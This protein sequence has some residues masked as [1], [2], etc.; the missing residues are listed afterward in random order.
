LNALPFFQNIK[1]ALTAGGTGG[2]TWHLHASLSRKKWQFTRDEIHKELMRG[3]KITAPQKIQL[4]KPEQN[5]VETIKSKELV[6]IGAS[7][8]WMMSTPWLEEFSLINAYDIDPLS[9][10]LFNINHGKALKRKGIKVK[11]HT[12]D[13]IHHLDH[14]LSS[15]PNAYIWFDNVLGQH[16]IRLRNADLANAQL[17]II[18]LRLRGRVWGSVH[19]LYSGPSTLKEHLGAQEYPKSVSVVR[20]D[21]NT[22]NQARVLYNSKEM[23]LEKARQTF[24]K[25]LGAS[26]AN[27]AWLDHETSN[28]FPVKTQLTWTGWAFKPGYYH[29]LEMGWVTPTLK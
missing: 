15:H 5:Q 18:Q 9:S 16:R 12:L 10:V 27:G 2:L 13:A 20:L 19:D 28:L 8:G 24:L 17:K 29:C 11:F 1:N 22:E 14:V 23:G 6:L 25:E 21:N 26:R 4:S 3:L 7:A